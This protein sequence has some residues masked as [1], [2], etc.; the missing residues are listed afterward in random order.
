MGAVSE[1]LFFEV[2][3]VWSGIKFFF[4]QQGI[5]SLSV[6]WYAEYGL[7]RKRMGRERERDGEGREKE[8]ERKE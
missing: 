8:R 5:Y 3:C 4:I 2:C 1:Q 7:G 6:L